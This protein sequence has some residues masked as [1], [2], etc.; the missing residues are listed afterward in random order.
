MN[1]IAHEGG[2][3]PR[4]ETIA[5]KY[6]L[7]EVLGVGGMGI[8]YRASQTCL[9]RTV[10]LKLVRPE[11]DKVPHVLRRFRN[12]ALA[13]SRLSHPNL[14]SVF[15][16]G[17]TT[18]GLMYLVMEHVCGRSLAQLVAEHGPMPLRRAA[19]LV[20]QLLAGL[21]ETHEAGIVHA[22]VKSDNILIQPHHNGT[23]LAKLIDF[24]LARFVDDPSPIA[25]VSLLSGTPEYLAPE[26]I[27]GGVPTAA[28]DLYAA[29]VIL[30]ELVAGTTPFG[31]GTADAILARHLEEDV[32][33]PSL[34]YPDRQIPRELERVVMQALEKDPAKRFPDANAFAAALVAATPATEP[35]L[36]TMM[37]SLFRTEAPT[38]DRSPSAL[39]SKS[40]PVRIAELREAVGRAIKMRDASAIVLRYL[41]LARGL[42]DDHQLAAAT[43]E[44][45]EG[46]ALLETGATTA[47]PIW[48]LQ[49]SLAA[50]YDGIG[51]PL[52][53][54]HA[55]FA[56]REQALRASDVVGQDRARELI[57]R[58][59]HGR[60]T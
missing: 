2:D 56:G 58:M 31:G 23:E 57:E 43:T 6:V 27:G 19:D 11:L 15:D 54:R 59:V 48:R 8:V 51:D 60:L 14:V 26:V 36:P 29:G 32:V 17:S 25:D 4:G 45:E 9:D 24:G 10:A 30:Y 3:H 28:A 21:A 44:L 52:R 40:Q 49:L 46:V 37:Q 1:A 38:R 16:F 39:S 7:G 20:G 35:V 34:R 42:I 18:A 22:D 33:L 53:A 55:A 41:E 50:L 13:G 47:T 5:D 12:E